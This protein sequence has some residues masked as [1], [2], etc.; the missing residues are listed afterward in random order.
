MVGNNEQ[1]KGTPYP[2]EAS[3]GLTALEA[4]RKLP[5]LAPTTQPA[6]A[7]A[8]SSQPTNG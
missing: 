2:A 4:A 5:A 3:A 8:P 7:A 1:L 6:A